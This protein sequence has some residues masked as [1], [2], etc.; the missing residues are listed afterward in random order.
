MCS[1]YLG[2]LVWA[3]TS[4]SW[5]LAVWELN[6]EEAAS[7]WCLQTKFWKGGSN[8]FLNTA[9]L[10]VWK[11]FCH[12][13]VLQLNCVAG[14]NKHIPFP[15]NIDWLMFIVSH[16]RLARNKEQSFLFALCVT[17]HDFIGLY[18]FFSLMSLFPSWKMCSHCLLSCQTFL[19]FYIFFIYDYYFF[20]GQGVGMSGTDN[21]TMCSIL[22]G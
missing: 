8:L 20:E 7:R 11:L 22:T 19:Y 3:Y 12:N 4:F 17:L 6:K 1:R 21:K 16:S 14:K 10:L 9:M 15:W 5:Q 18:I 13:G 2:N